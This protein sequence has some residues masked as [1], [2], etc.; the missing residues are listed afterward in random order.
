MFSPQGF[1]SGQLIYDLTVSFD[2][3]HEYL[4]SFEP[5]RRTYLIIAVADHTENNDLEVLSQQLEELKFLVINLEAWDVVVL[6][7][8]NLSSTRELCIIHAWSSIHPLSHP[9]RASPPDQ[10]MPARSDW[11]SYLYRRSESLDLRPCEP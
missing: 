6:A 11:C 5:Y 8:G 3:E 7:E 10:K 9:T 4:E 1:P 2:R